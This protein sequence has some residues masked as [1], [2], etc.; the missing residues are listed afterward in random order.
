MQ[1]MAWGGGGRRPSLAAPSSSPGSCL[2][3]F[4]A[5][6]AGR[7]RP[8]DC[9]PW[10]P[11]WGRGE[12]RR[13]VP[14]PPRAVDPG[15]PPSTRVGRLPTAPPPPRLSASLEGRGRGGGG[16]R[17]A[18]RE[19]TAAAESECAGASSGLRFS[20]PGSARSEPARSACAHA[21][22]RPWSVLKPRPRPLSNQTSVLSPQATPNFLLSATSTPLN[23]PSVP[24]M[25]SKPHFTSPKLYPQT[26]VH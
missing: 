25:H 10:G 18:G 9:E 17:G 11:D 3:P 21:F 5:L 22:S 2:L 12:G 20:C 23:S 19:T 1:A 6:P 4:R 15:P 8:R 24:Q 7:V 16:R 14:A 26:T 13:G